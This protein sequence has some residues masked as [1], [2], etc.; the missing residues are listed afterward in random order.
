MSGG[1]VAAITFIIHLALWLAIEV[2]WWISKYKRSKKWEEIS[3]VVMS[4]LAMYLIF[5]FVGDMFVK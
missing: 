4:W 5:L 3:F 1:A 2:I